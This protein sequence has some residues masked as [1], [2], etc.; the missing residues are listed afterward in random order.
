MIKKNTLGALALALATLTATG[1]AAAQ[2]PRSSGIG[3]FGWTVRLGYD[4]GG[5]KVARLYYT[6]RTTQDLHTGRGVGVQIGGYYRLANLP[7]EF[8]ATV[9][10][11]GD[12]SSAS[13]ANVELNRMVTELRADYHLTDALWV[14]A[15]PVWHSDVKLHGDGVIPDQAFRN[16]TGMTVVVGYNWFALSYTSM[17]YQDT[18]GAR[19]DASSIGVSMIG[20]F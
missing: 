5:D 18:Y 15:G 7:L 3:K 2:E 19:Y 13:N 6:D 1:P 12:G 9:G 20:K 17:K 16:A 8:T 4:V 14:G 10:I 11:K